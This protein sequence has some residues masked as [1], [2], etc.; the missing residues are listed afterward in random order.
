ML[1]PAGNVKAKLHSNVVSLLGHR[2]KEKREDHPEDVPK[3]S[4]MAS[5]HQTPVN[6]GTMLPCWKLDDVR[7]SGDGANDA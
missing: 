3:V 2:G 7:G 5:T 4:Q 1:N 6:P